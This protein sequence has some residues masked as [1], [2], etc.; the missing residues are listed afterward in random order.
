M[1]GSHPVADGRM[2]EAFLASSAGT[3]DS[4][5]ETDV[6]AAR[7]RLRDEMRSTWPDA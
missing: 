1:I 3:S 2:V 6:T 5:F 7:E 4:A